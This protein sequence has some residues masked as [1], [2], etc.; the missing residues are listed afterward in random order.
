[1]G[2]FSRI[3]FLSVLSLAQGLLLVPD[4]STTTF[5]LTQS[6]GSVRLWTTPQ[7]RRVR[8]SSTAVPTA[9]GS[10]LSVFCGRE[11]L[12][13][14]Q[15]IVAP[16]SAG[17]VV[18]N[19]ANFAG[20][21]VDAW[22][23]CA[24]AQFSPVSPWGQG[25]W[26]VTD[27]LMIVADGGTVPL[28]SS[29]PT[30]LWFTVYVPGETCGKTTYT[31]DIILTPQ[32]QAPIVVPVSLY[33]FDVLLDREPHM[34]TNGESQP[35]FTGASYSVAQLDAM[36]L[37]YAQHR[38]SGRSQSW[39]AGLNYQVSWN[40][41]TNT[42]I[43]VDNA[44]ST[45]ACVWA[46]GCD[47]RRYVIGQS[48][49]WKG[50]QYSALPATAQSEA[51][52]TEG[53]RPD[54]F[55]GKS[56]NTASTSWDSSYDGWMCDASYEAAWGNYM[57]QLVAW[58]TAN[59]PNYASRTH[60]LWYT[61]NEPQNWK[62]YTKSAYL[63][64]QARTRAPGMK[65]MVSR[66][67]H[68]W[69]YN[70]GDA[71]D[72]GYDVWVG[73]INRI[74]LYR[75]WNRQ[76][77]GE[78]SWM[79]FLDTDAGCHDF[80]GNTGVICAP[81]LAPFISKTGNNG[82]MNPIATND[83]MHYRA[84][85]WVLFSMRIEGWLYYKDDGNTLWDSSNMNAAGGYKPAR[86]RVSAAL[87]REGL[88]DYEY[89]YAANCRQLPKVFEQAVA[90]PVAGSIGS[91]F[92]SWRNTATAEDD[93]AALRIE[94]GKYLEGT[95]GDMPFL[96]QPKLFDFGSYNIDF[97]PDATQTNPTFTFNSSTWMKVDFEQNYD[98]A[99]GIGFQSGQM[100]LPNWIQP[101][102]KI[103]HC[104]DVGNGDA[105]QRTVCFNDFNKND[106]FHMSLFP[107]TYQVTVGM[108][109][110]GSTRNGDIEYVEVNDVI[111][112]NTT[113]STVPGECRG[114]R[115]YTQTVTV[116]SHGSGGQLI[117]KR[118]LCF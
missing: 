18:V 82:A 22:L 19:F 88:E 103:F 90:D 43:D 77:L 70:R 118:A 84:I 72:C 93:L 10:S 56:C 30:V 71:F 49:W 108:G 41:N 16:S 40:S 114:V 61:V 105:V 26:K 102:K 104:Q 8:D 48:G 106:Q 91:L 113:C 17:S 46:N 81:Y 74:Q 55:D 50:V 60:G 92:A 33:V 87:M 96:V 79:Y 42:L 117:S 83:G 27:K 51:M 95:R 14:F 94:L 47:Y 54:P 97:A 31:T 23:E 5:S 76:V 78:K 28:S 6:T 57:Q 80:G 75:T 66:E 39:P 68:P 13:S 86:P 115:E 24:E 98:I 3:L 25:S 73:H 111:F 36:K 38:L 52:S 99:S 4:P 110:P 7:T 53:G 29:Q 34:A 89:L 101:G 107:G 12:E 64:K 62:D 45:T 59:V 65:V 32:S 109:W 2:F 116:K 63:C 69:I 37:V 67:A 9:T 100:G 1:M 85:P 11:E 20:L 44:T 15:L 21:P 35:K 112:R 58:L